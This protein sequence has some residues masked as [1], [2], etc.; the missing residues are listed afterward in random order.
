MKIYWQ[1]ILF[2]HV[3][4]WTIWKYP[5]S[6]SLHLHYLLLAKTDLLCTLHAQE[7]FTCIYHIRLPSQRSIPIVSATLIWCECHTNYMEYMTPRE[8]HAKVLDSTLPIWGLQ[9][10]C[11]FIKTLF[12]IPSMNYLSGAV[13]QLL[14]TIQ[15]MQ[16][17]KTLQCEDDSQ[18]SDLSTSSIGCF[19]HHVSC[20]QS[21]W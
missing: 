4:E 5:D 20:L 8:C 17:V 13:W 7:P 15:N 11:Q 16:D 3:L 12:T 19:P 6:F 2:W 10:W 18:K 21:C 1:P 14:L 9:N